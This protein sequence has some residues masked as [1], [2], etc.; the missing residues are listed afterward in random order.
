MA[1]LK[2][3]TQTFLLLNFELKRNHWDSVRSILTGFI[4]IQKLRSQHETLKKFVIK[5]KN[6]NQDKELSFLYQKIVLKK[7]TME[8][9]YCH[10]PLRSSEEDE[11][12]RSVK[13]FKECSRAR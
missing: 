2:L 11:L 8:A 12:G 5:R 4:L 6:L 13:K 9:K 3:F 1:Q 10:E 7:E